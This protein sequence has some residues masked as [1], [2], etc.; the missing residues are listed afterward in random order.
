MQ[1]Y[2]SS[3]L[4]SLFAIAVEAF[5]LQFKEWSEM[6]F[7]GFSGRADVFACLVADS[8]AMPCLACEVKVPGNDPLTDE[9][10]MQAI[11]VWMFCDIWTHL[12]LRVFLGD[13][14]LRL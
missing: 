14:G 5:Q 8:L 2:F 1:V 3:L 13:L 11:S 6:A 9:V 12:N 4:E 7:G 10:V